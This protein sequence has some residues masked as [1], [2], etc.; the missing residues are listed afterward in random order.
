MRHIVIDPRWVQ[1]R[2]VV[3]TDPELLHHVV[4]VLRLGRGE[5]LECSD[6][7]GTRYTTQV[8][9]TSRARL[10]LEILSQTHEPGSPV[11]VRLAPALVKPERFDWLVQKAT[12][13]GAAR[14]SPMM[15]ERT[16]IRPQAER[17]AGRAARWQRIAKEAAQQCGLT[18]LPVIDAPVPYTDVLASLDHDAHVLLPTLEVATQPLRQALKTWNGGT[19]MTVLIGPEGD[20]TRGEA[21]LA[22][23]RGAVP[24][25]LGRRTLRSETA[26]IAVLAILQHRAGEL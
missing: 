9:G 11:A 5:R 14:I 15:S 7:A 2:S 18:S 21:S 20:F 12:E 3:V 6:G 25:S 17:A 10:E 8:V 22:M 16:V 23:Q 24:V 26:A 4:D 19:S 13:L 1:D